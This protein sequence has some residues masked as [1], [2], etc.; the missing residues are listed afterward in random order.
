MGIGLALG[1]PGSLDNRSYSSSAVSSAITSGPRAGGAGTGGGEM[2][3][4]TGAAADSGGLSRDPI[5][6]LRLHRSLLGLGG[7]LALCGGK[8]QKD[9]GRHGFD[10][11]RRHGGGVTLRFLAS[12]YLLAADLL[13]ESAVLQLHHLLAHA[14]VAVVELSHDPIHCQDHS[15]LLLTNTKGKILGDLMP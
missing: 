10:R 11:H 1:F 14:V 7:S 9:G 15:L 2:A 3:T 13:Q 6:R 5:A 12:R 8:R 4:A